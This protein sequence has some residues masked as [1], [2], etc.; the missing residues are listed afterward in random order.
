MLARHGPF[1]DAAAVFSAV[2]DGALATAA[3]LQADRH[4]IVVFGPDGVPRLD[5][6]FVDEGILPAEIALLLDNGMRLASAAARAHRLANQSDSRP[7]RLA[8][9]HNLTNQSA[10]R[11]ASAPARRLLF[12]HKIIDDIAGELPS[13]PERTDPLIAAGL[14]EVFGHRYPGGS[15]PAALERVRRR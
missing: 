3:V 13:A 1:A 14:A 8:S 12:F 9:P 11:N 5:A 2:R 7:R 6:H 15:A 10:A 4:P